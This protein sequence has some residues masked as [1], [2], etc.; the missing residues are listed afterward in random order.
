ML[1]NLFVLFLI[2]I[3]LISISV[4]FD[5]V[6]Q[7]FGVG[8]EPGC[9]VVAAEGEEIVGVCGLLEGVFIG[10]CLGICSI[11]IMEFVCISTITCTRNHLFYLN[12]LL[13]SW[14]SFPSP[15]PIYH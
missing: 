8:E 1:L 4:I 15:V 3:S 10:F 11:S 6:L 5:L 13:F 14:A 12:C 7:L 2:R 9:E